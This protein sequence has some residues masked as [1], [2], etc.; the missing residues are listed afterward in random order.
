MRD[1]SVLC[2]HGLGRT[3][4]DW[5]GVREG[6]ARYGT[7]HMPQL[8]RAT[9]EE[10]VAAD[11][12][13]AAIVIGH[14]LSGVVAIRRTAETGSAVRA[15]VLTDSFFPPARNGRTRAAMLA[16]Y[17]SHRIALGRELAARREGRRPR[18]A[19]ARAM[20][21]LARLGLR[22]DAFHAAASAVRA[23]VLVLHGGSDHHVPVDFAIAAANRHRD[24]TIRIVD[25]ADHNFHVDRPA[26]W[27]ATASSWLD[28]LP[29]APNEGLRPGGWTPP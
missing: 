21:S 12:P 5:D 15:L 6:L 28:A 29:A 19:T 2:L 7:V 3:V 20:R 22:P 25:G 24:W 13:R 8:P 27:L 9:L 18:R 16:D 10:L 26:E 23:P 14:S 17:G 11:L 4:S 1:A